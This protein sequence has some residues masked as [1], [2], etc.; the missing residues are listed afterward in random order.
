MK[1]ITKLKSN[2]TLKNVV[3]HLKE[4]F[5]LE[6]NVKFSPSS[7]SFFLLLSIIPVLTI[8]AM[9]LSF[10]NY[11]IFYFF[12]RLSLDS[13]L[14]KELYDSFKL[15]FSNPPLSEKIPFIITLSTIAYLSS[16]GLY[17]FSYAY[18]R[19]SD[20]S[21]PLNFSLK[22]RIIFV[23]LSLILEIL[24]AFFILFLLA[25]TNFFNSF[26]IILL[27]VFLSLITFIFLNVFISFIYSISQ[28]S[29]HNKRPIIL[30]S[31]ISSSLITI[32]TTAYSFYLTKISKTLSYF[33]PLSN[34]F[35]F[36]LIVYFISYALLLGVE[37]N[38]KWYELHTTNRKH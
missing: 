14:S 29:N 21:L 7:L 9:I 28:L 27:E 15:F 36:I 31:F 4:F 3:S 10:F 17:F 2:K 30:G 25:I 11:D 22:R 8:I 34:L 32:G 26:N 35:L 13:L 5:T 33:G 16:K 18:I 37:A 24:V 23:I 6:G 19:I 20:I 38:K 1:K 12:D